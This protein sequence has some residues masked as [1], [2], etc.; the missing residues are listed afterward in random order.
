MPWGCCPLGQD[1]WAVCVVLLWMEENPKIHDDL[2]L[3][4]GSAA[5][6]IHPSYREL[7]GLHGGVGGAAAWPCIPVMQ[8]WW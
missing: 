2:W 4:R 1:G 8:C 7:G 5:A 6:V 3:P